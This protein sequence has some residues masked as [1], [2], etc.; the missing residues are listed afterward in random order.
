MSSIAVI[1]PGIGYTVDRSLLYFTGKLASEA[2]YDRV[3]VRFS[4]FESGVKGDPSK[5]QRAFEHAYRQ[6][7]EQLPELKQDDDVL[8]ISK[9]IGTAASLRADAEKG[10]R[11]RHIIFTPLMETMT[12]LEDLLQKQGRD[13]AGDIIVF[14]GLSDPWADDNAVMKARAEKAGV[15]YYETENAN[16]SLETGDPVA[17]MGLQ[18]HIM[19]VCRD[20][21]ANGR[22]EGCCL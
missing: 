1:V 13:R 4:G 12:Q 18:E 20:F 3:N 22:A 2:G 21:I 10:I 9:S 6:L 19:Q 14:H 7:C 5:I 17:D 8:F 15:A 11:A 16:H